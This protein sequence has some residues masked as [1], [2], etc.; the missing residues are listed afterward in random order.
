MVFS[1]SESDFL[2][3]DLVKVIY[4]VAGRGKSSVIN[5]F[6]QSRNIPYLWTTSTNKLKRDAQERYGCEASTVCSAL[7]T[8]ENG[9]FYLEE[10]DPEYKNIIIDEIL[11]TSPKVLDWIKNHKGRYNIIVLTDTHQMLAR[12]DGVI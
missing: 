12:E 6:F 5:D 7:F 8:S 4:G 9:H 2:N 11:Q 1:F 10:K 3:P